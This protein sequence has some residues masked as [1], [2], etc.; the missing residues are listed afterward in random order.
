MGCLLRHGGEGLLMGTR[1]ELKK[2]RGRV[3]KKRGKGK[4]F[5][6]THREQSA[7]LLVQAVN[8]LH[9]WWWWWWW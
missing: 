5:P 3:S 7:P 1:R 8:K 2:K 4:Y 9:M 6:M